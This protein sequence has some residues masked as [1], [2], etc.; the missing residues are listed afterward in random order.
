MKLSNKV[1][2]KWPI[3]YFKDM[4][5][6]KAVN[7]FLSS[8]PVQIFQSDTNLSLSLLVLSLSLYPSLLSSILSVLLTFLTYRTKLLT[9][10]YC[11]KNTLKERMR[12]GMQLP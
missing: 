4:R 7:P 6:T 11:Y 9:Y 8:L 12:K 3:L 5:G 2:G 1:V 10:N